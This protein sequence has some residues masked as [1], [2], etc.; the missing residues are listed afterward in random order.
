[1]TQRK[2]TKRRFSPEF[3]LK[4]IEQV[5]KYQQRAVDVAQS[6]DLDPSQLRKWIRQYE[7]EIQGIT[8]A[9]VALTP[10]QCR[11]QELEKQVRRLDMEKEILKQA[12]VLMSEIPVK[13]AR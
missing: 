9:G 1:M 8:P 7:A 12:A 10:D 2:R 6:L 5:I 13:S 4:A 3:K 11:I